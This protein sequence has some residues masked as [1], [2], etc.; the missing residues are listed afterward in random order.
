MCS[1]SPAPSAVDPAFSYP[2]K[3]EDVFDLPAD[4]PTASFHDPSAS[5][6]YAPRAGG[7]S[8]MHQDATVLGTGLYQSCSSSSLPGSSFR[9]PRGPDGSLGSCP[10]G[11]NNIAYVHV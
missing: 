8:P 10:A 7:P 5:R 3:F 6:E 11:L 1:T 4:S 2:L 9:S